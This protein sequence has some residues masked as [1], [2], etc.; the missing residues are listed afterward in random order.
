VRVRRLSEQAGFRPMKE[1]LGVSAARVSRQ[2]YSLPRLFKK[3]RK[4]E[5]RYGSA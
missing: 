2:L 4:T 5:M 3:I 1:I